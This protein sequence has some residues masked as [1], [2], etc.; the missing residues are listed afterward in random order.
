[1][2]HKK[3][4][5]LEMGHVTSGRDRYL[6]LRTLNQEGNVACGEGPYIRTGMLF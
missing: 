2:L 4:K 5:L 1:M 3:A 6:R